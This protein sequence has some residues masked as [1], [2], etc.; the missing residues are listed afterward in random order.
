MK[1]S[2]AMWSDGGPRA[3]D[4]VDAEIVADFVV[5][6]YSKS[7]RVATMSTSMGVTGTGFSV[8]CHSQTA[9]VDPF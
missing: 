4:S 1:Q 7:T 6:G 8:D 2:Y 5:N 9:Q 3:D